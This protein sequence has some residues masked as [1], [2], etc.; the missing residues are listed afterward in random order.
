MIPVN[1]V[2]PGPKLRGGWH[3]EE[4]HGFWGEAL[5]RLRVCIEEDAV[6]APPDGARP[7]LLLVV[8]GKH[9]AG[10]GM[11]TWRGHKEG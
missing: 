5:D 9:R 2:T 7:P 4:L 10:Q 8:G 3:L 11:D 6:A 1:G